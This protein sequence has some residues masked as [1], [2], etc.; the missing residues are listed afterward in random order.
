MRGLALVLAVVATTLAA[1]VYSGTAL[2]ANTSAWYWPA[3][4]CKSS[5]Q[6]N[7]VQF[8]DGR[9]FNVAKAFCVGL[10]NHCWL[11]DG[12][13]R[14]KVFAVAARSYDGVVR[15]FQLTVTGQHTWRGE[16]N[17]ILER[18][19][20]ASAFANRYGNAAW[21]VASLENQRGC[22]DIHP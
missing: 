5:L 13:R 17:K 15:G 7:G 8:N 22:Y 10:H 21:S 3:G 2:S 4:S 6:N 11:S 18:Y 19:M 12:V 20:S 1:A 9:T 14:Y 16:K